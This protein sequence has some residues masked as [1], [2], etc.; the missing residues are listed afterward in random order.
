MFIIFNISNKDFVLTHFQHCRIKNTN[1]IIEFVEFFFFFFSLIMKVMIFVGL[2][3]KVV[4]KIKDSNTIL[5]EMTQF[6]REMYNS[7][8]KIQQ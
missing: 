3:M 2:V 4:I 6:D 7:R 5:T 8:I 1:K